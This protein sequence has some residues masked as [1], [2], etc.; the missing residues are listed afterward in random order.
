MRTA[1][2]QRSQLDILLIMTENGYFSTFR[3]NLSNDNRQKFICRIV[4]I[5]EFQRSQ[6]LSAEN[7]ER[8]S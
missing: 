1:R 3:G 2:F 5:L 7:R 6:S 8:T 4:N